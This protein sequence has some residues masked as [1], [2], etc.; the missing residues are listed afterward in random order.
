MGHINIR[1]LEMY[2]AETP[3]FT[4]RMSRIIPA[5]EWLR[6]W[7]C[8]SCAVRQEPD[9][10]LCPS[11]LVRHIVKCS[12]ENIESQPDI[13]GRMLHYDYFL[14]RIRSIS[15]QPSASGRHIPAAAPGDQQGSQHGMD[16]AV[17]HGWTSLCASTDFSAGNFLIKISQN[18]S[19]MRQSQMMYSLAVTVIQSFVLQGCRSFANRFCL[20]GLCLYPQAQTTPSSAGPPVG[21]AIPT[22]RITADAQPTMHREDEYRRCLMRLVVY[23]LESPGCRRHALEQD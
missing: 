3:I 17:A 18:F 12:A 23:P 8:P 10:L 2:F 4:C 5:R 20:C 13:L 9:L 19:A 22:E 14:R 16:L 11:L 7:N 1:S 15:P 21:R 6:H